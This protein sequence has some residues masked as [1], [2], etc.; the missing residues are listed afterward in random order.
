MLKRCHF[1]SVPENWVS[2]RHCTLLWTHHWRLH[3]KRTWFFCWSSPDWRCRSEASDAERLCSIVCICLA[4]CASHLYTRDL[5]RKATIIYG[6][7]NRTCL[8]WMEDATH[9]NY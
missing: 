9:S 7:T 3:C 1:T 6:A 4:K 2:T 8:F 5:V